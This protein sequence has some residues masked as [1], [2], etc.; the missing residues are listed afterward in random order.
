[1]NMYKVFLPAALLATLSTGAQTKSITGFPET[2]APQQFALEKK[3]D[4]SLSADNVG[5]TVKLLSSKPHNLGSPGGKDVADEILKKF[6][7]YGWNA[8]LNVYHVLFPTP[9][10]RLLEM[11]APAKYKAVLREFPFKED[12]SSGQPGQLPPY[13]AWSPDGD[14]TA[15]LVFVNYG[16]PADYEWLERLG[17]SVKGKIV[18]AKYGRSWRGIKPKIAQEHGAVGCI[19]YSDPADDGYTAGDVYPKGAF[20]NE[21]SVQRG[22]VMDMPVYPGDPSTPGTASTENAKR[23]DRTEATNLLKIPVLPIGYHDAEPL[24]K[25]LGGEVVPQGWQGALPFTYHIGNGTTNVHLKL[26]FNWDI[27][28]CYN[29]VA[30]IPGAEFPDEWIMRGN[31]HDAW[32]HGAD[33]PISGQAALLEEAKAIGELL[34][35][36]WKPKRTIVY[37]AWDGEE[38][39]LL[40]STEYVEDNLDELKKKAVVYINTDG[41]SRGF[42]GAGGSHALQTFVNEVARDV[43]DPQTNVSVAQRLLARNAFTAATTAQ[44]K[45]AFSKKEFDLGA[46]GSG[47]DYSPFFQ[48]GGI[49]SLNIG[50]GGEG[51]GG[52]YHTAFDSYEN[53]VRFKDP[54]FVY[55]VALAQTVGYAVLRFA[56]ADLLPFKYNQLSKTI[57]TY[58]DQLVQLNNELR[59]S[60]A[61]EADMSKAGYFKLVTD[62]ANH[63][64][65]LSLKPEVPFLNF[66]PLQN[67]L[68]E[69]QKVTDSLDKKLKDGVTNANDL[70]E[71]N[72]KLYT[73]EQQLLLSQGLPRR[74]WYKHSIYAPG[75]YTGYG[76]KTLPII[77]EALEQYN[78]EEAQQGIYDVAKA[79]KQ[80]AEYL[81]K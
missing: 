69:L 8:K 60:R 46:L 58:A 51:D 34:K 11:T 52:E 57:K 28:P 49:P 50:Y 37:C 81:K 76:V 1:M 66:A 59:E 53:Y 78:W 7:S 32:V 12:A 48:H 62:T 41:N 30:S 14:V 29:V 25:S 71:I 35:T 3:F 10:T 15:P 47:S 54:S 43:I 6:Q 33:D 74:P 42:L 55:G 27:V 23:I 80:M 36:G 13:N 22:S 45:E 68:M 56:N 18:I 20:K 75:F 9:K 79:L 64:K 38:P 17:V 26:A 44:K 16:L 40:G 77:R 5:K 61:I 63:F 4:A 19:I 73:A 72:Y 2:S 24:L 31:H 39:A 21:Y 70:K 65:E 67:E